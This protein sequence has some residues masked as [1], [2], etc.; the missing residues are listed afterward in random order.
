MQTEPT[1]ETILGDAVETAVETKRPLDEQ[2]WQNLQA[3]VA[4]NI[5]KADRQVKSH[6]KVG[7]KTSHYYRWM[8]VRTAMVFMQNYLLSVR[9]STPQG[10]V[11]DTV[12]TTDPKLG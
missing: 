1:N 9:T 3:T 2:L 5:D 6:E 11:S 10:D 8:G 12:P 4:I 7:M